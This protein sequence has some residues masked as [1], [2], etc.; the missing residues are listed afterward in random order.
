MTFVKPTCQLSHNLL[1][2]KSKPLLIFWVVK[3]LQNNAT[4]NLKRDDE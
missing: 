2:L 4:L 1:F 3:F